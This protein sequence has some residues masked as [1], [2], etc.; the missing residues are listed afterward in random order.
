MTCF[1]SPRS[2]ACVLL[3]ASLGQPASLRAAETPSALET[4]E[5]RILPIFHSQRPSSCTECH[6]S[7]IELKDYIR[8][9]Q[10]ETFSALVQAGMI[11]LKNPDDSKILTFIDRK[12]A[13]P[14]LIAE[15]V[16]REE[17]EAFR[18]WITAAVRDPRLLAAR[19]KTVPIGPT[20]PDA[21]IRHARSDRVLGSFIEN[22]WSEVTR[23]DHCHSPQYNQ[24]AV[25]RFGQEF[26]E[27]ISWIRPGDPRGTLD[28]L[29]KSGLID[30][31]EPEDSLLLAKPSLRE[32]HKG[33][34]KMAVG[35]RAYKQ[36]LRFLTDYAA[37]AKGQ[38]TSAAQL[39]SPSAEVAM[40]SDLWLRIIDVPARYDQKVLRVELHGWDDSQGAWSQDRCATADWVVIGKRQLWQFSLHLTAPR[41]SPGAEEIRQEKALPPGRYLAK[42]FIDEAGKLE[43]DS[44][45]ELGS[46]EFIGA[47]DFRAHWQPGMAKAVEIHF[48]PK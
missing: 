38:Y 15:N 3:L 21:V 44:L 25:E 34:R 4:F 14:S 43:R 10:G 45:A 36:F 1:S 46:D 12:P 27:R 35:D 7:G 18:A 40:L 32:P 39:P 20:V 19:A 41:D 9:D 29:V 28:R 30:L 31:D 17:Y 6:L 22:V 24:K 16:R 26:V 33:G 8:P 11:D 2:I 37:V 48:P 5:Q 42:I 13:A 23:C 47:V